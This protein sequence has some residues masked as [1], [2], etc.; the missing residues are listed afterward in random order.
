MVMIA[1]VF[2]CML[3]MHIIEDFHLQGLLANMKQ[4]NWWKQELSKYK[5]LPYFKYKNDY[6]VA[7]ILHSFEWAFC[8]CLP[9]A[10]WIYKSYGI[11][12]FNTTFFVLFI[13]NTCLHA[14]VDDLKCNKFVINLWQDQLIH[15]IQII[16]WIGTY[17]F[18][19][20]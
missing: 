5:D 11:A 19:G 20:V 6:I 8:V 2:T 12:G 3:F 13:C 1:L 18:V 16:A 15:I 7:L 10:I 14:I 4:K 9:L 17:K